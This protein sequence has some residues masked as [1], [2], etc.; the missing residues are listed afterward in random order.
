[1]IRRGVLTQYL[2]ND[3]EV[4]FPAGI[5]KIGKSV[6]ESRHRKQIT[7]VTIPE[8][9]TE[10]SDG[11]FMELTKLEHIQL[12]AS[13]QTIGNKAFAVCISLRQITI[14]DG[15]TTLGEGC[16]EY[17]ERLESVQLPAALTE[18]PGRLFC[19][20]GRL[21]QVN[22]PA[23]ITGVGDG[24]FASCRRLQA[25]QLPDTVQRIGEYSFYECESLETVTIPDTCRPHDRAFACCKSLVDEAGRQILQNRLYG[26]YG[27]A[28]KLVIPD[29]VTEIVNGA[30]LGKGECHVEM[31]LRCP[32]WAWSPRSAEYDIAWVLMNG[33]DS[34]ISFRDA[35]GQIVAKVILANR[36]EQGH[37]Q[38]YAQLS[39]RQK[40][41]CFDFAWYDACWEQ[42]EQV[43]NRLKVALVRLRYPYALSPWAQRAYENAVATHSLE[44][45]KQVIDQADSQ[46]LG[47]LLEK[48]L[49]QPN[50]LL[51]LVDYA[52]E[53]GNVT[54]TAQLLNAQAQCLT[55]P[56]QV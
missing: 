24:A 32:Q 25:V 47:Q 7:A 56:W 55:D 53:K 12:P 44:A 14:P 35:A 15:V 4:I 48:R 54:L 34:S 45:G 26:Y 43:A 6:F 42:L 50:C 22:I 29:A 3:R 33:A 1:M 20:C 18:I 39:L 41:G 13:L 38:S 31:P 10:I 51:Q 2:G 52:S 23:G 9:V 28:P 11:A 30:L 17:C 21:T 19:M 27:S 16:F 37:S 8:G 49:L 40:D 36:D 5:R 46:L